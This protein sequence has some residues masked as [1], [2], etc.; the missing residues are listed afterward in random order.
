MAF[1]GVG[2]GKVNAGFDAR[3]LKSRIILMHDGPSVCP[4]CKVRKAVF[5]GLDSPDKT[6]NKDIISQTRKPL[7]HSHAP[8]TMATQRRINTTEKTHLDQ[9]EVRLEPK[10]NITPAVPSFVSPMP[11]TPG[12]IFLIG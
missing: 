4:V 5:K 9:D 10:S 7:G 8:T 6:D 12:N 2:Q 3:I 11:A 1:T